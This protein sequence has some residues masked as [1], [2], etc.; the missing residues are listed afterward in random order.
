M[1]KLAKPAEPQR[2]V[3][4]P[5]DGEE[6]EAFIIVAPITRA[7]RRRALGAARRFLESTGVDAAQDLSADQLTDMSEIVSVELCRLG[8]ME[9]GGIGDA[10]GELLDLTPA[11]DTRFATAG[12]PERPTGTID[13]L[14]AD[15]A[16]LK[17]LDNDYVIPDAL[18]LAEKNGLSGL[19]S[20]T[21]KGATPGKGTASLAAKR[22]RKAAAPRARTAKTSSKP[23]RAKRPG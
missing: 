17:K 20:G 3:L 11:L 8:V 2:I 10:D 9:W 14:L 13:L 5:A 22:T 19:P 18:R 12:D 21:G 23:K 6:P 16:V 4:R 7:M 15:E 1:L